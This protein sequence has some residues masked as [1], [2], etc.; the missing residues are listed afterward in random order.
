MKARPV[1]KILSPGGSKS[2]GELLKPRSNQRGFAFGPFQFK[3]LSKGSPA[4]LD[5]PGVREQ[6]PKMGFK[7]HGLKEKQL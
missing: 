5:A 6:E 2:L 1:P 3:P 4:L 7:C